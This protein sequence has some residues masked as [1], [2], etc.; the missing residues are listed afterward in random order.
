MGN[1]EKLRNSKGKI[2]TVANWQKEISWSRERRKSSFKKEE[3][4]PE[5]LEKS[6][7]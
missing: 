6:V 4:K 3:L 7:E 5:L 1:F 2:I